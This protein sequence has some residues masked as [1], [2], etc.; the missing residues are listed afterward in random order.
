MPHTIK[1]TRTAVWM[2]AMAGLGLSLSVNAQ[3]A[4]LLDRFYPDQEVVLLA[5]GVISTGQAEFHP[6]YDLSRNELYF[7]RRTPGIFDY[8]IYCTKLTE[9]GWSEPVIAPFSGQFRDAAPYLA[10]D[11]ATLFFDSSRPDPRVA[12]NSINLWSTKRTETAWNQPVLLQEASENEAGE[13]VA[14]RD[15]FGPAVDQ[16]G[17]LFFYSFRRPFRG[18]SHYIAYP[19]DYQKV[20][21]KPDLPDPSA[22]T[23]VAYLYISPD[24]KIA[25]L[26]GRARGRS[27]RDLYCACLDEKGKWGNPVEISSVNTP[28]E[29]G[30][31]ALTSDGRYLLFTS[32]RPT[33]ASG[34][35]NDNLYIVPASEILQFCRAESP[36]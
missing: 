34:A 8:T 33:G 29:E 15:E 4:S 13:P 32:N 28:S 14:G 6:T 1:N 35:L 3:E 24:G 9:A 5:P 22:P 18:G 16:S 36:K 10:P 19:P 23:F 2:A 30:Q 7:M 21:R 26:E 31:P 11:G 25:L 12:E 27:D 17:R 20:T